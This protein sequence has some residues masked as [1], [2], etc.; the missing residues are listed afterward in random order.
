MLR[1]HGA[2][3]GIFINLRQPL[4]TSQ[5]S[6][7]LESGGMSNTAQMTLAAALDQVEAAVRTA[8]ADARRDKALYHLERLRMAL[9]ASHQEGVRFAAFTLTKTVRDAAADWGQ[10]AVAAVDALGASLRAEGHHF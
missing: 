9:A 8:P 5:S 6:L 3:N 1:H 4:S 10:A 2:E 7:R